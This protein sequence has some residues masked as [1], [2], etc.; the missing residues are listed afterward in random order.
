MI[1]FGPEV[2][3]DL[4]AALKLVRHPAAIVSAATVRLLTLASSI[5][6]PKNIERSSI[7]LAIPD[8]CPD[9]AEECK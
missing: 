3:E 2:C 1:R 9:G 5:P 7:S 8:T 4:T 6:S